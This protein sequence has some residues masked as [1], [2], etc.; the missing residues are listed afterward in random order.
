MTGQRPHTMPRYSRDDWWDDAACKGQ[1][2]VV[3]ARNTPAINA[4]K[5]ICATCPVIEDCL[6]QALS[7]E[8]RLPMW[9]RNGVAGGMTRRER[10]D[11][12][13]SVCQ[14]CGEPVQLGHIYCDTHKA[15]RHAESQRRHFQAQREARRNARHQRGVAS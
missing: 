8:A 3:E 5:A 2:W 4:A 9:L 14:D 15:T 1:T 7:M 12:S 10:Y 13:R 6:R 11:L